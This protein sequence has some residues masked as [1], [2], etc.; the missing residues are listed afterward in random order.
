MIATEL[1]NWKK[2][3][4][5]INKAEIHKIMDNDYGWC[6]LTNKFGERTRVDYTMTL[7]QVKRII[8]RITNENKMTARVR[9]HLLK[10]I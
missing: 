7:Q 4:I 2:I 10:Q 8:E 5:I 6:Y 3:S 9:K 1:Q